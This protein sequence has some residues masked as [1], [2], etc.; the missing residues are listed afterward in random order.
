MAQ[1]DLPPEREE[2][3]L[4]ELQHFEPEKEKWQE[5]SSLGFTRWLPGFNV[6]FVL[7]FL[8]ST[9]QLKSVEVHISVWYVVEKY[10]KWLLTQLSL[11]QCL[12]A[13]LDT[14]TLLREALITSKAWFILDV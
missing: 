4:L 5:E 11:V 12:A 9:W 13:G 3:A 10:Q 2:T 7:F 6:S 8:H 14:P 1:L